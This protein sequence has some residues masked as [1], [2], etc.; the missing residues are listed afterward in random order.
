MKIKRLV[1]G[2]EL[3]PADENKKALKQFSPDMF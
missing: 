3:L 2:M 1:D